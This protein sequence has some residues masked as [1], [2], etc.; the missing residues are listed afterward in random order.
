M[1]LY[2]VLLATAAALLASNNGFAV[3]DE[4]CTIVTKAPEATPATP[5]GSSSYASSGSSVDTPVTQ[6]STAA[7]DVGASQESSPDSPVQQ[8]SNPGSDV[9]DS[10]ASTSNA[11]DTEQPASGSYTPSSV[12]ASQ[13]TD[14]ASSAETAGDADQ[15]L[16]FT[17]VP[18][19]TTVA[20]TVVSSSSASGS[21]SSS[22]PTT[23]N[24]ST[25]PST[26]TTTADNS[27]LCAKPRIEITEVDV[28]AAVDANED[29]AALKLVAIA[30]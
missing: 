21:S 6:D 1:R 11:D 14:V 22:V 18:K 12:D 25:T 17:E 8:F 7:S 23:S 16:T 10:E 2:H 19:A 24:N 27:K 20:P 4:K 3:A 29:E 13:N 30:A 26:S 28:G 15:S 5:I 9:G